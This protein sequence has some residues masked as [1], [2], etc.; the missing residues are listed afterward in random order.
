MMEMAHVPRLVT[1]HSRNQRITCSVDENHICIDITMSWL[2]WDV[3][4]PAV[5]L[6]MPDMSL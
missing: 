6:I 4:G 1:F 2:R 5:G 3:L